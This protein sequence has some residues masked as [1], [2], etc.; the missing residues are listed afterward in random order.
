MANIT[1]Y[2]GP[3]KCG[4]SQKLFNEL[5][6]QLIAGKKLEIFKP[7]LDNR[8]GMEVISTRAGNSIKAH[9]IKNIKELK[10]YDADVYFID[11]FQFLDGDVSIIESIA[12]QE[13]KFYIAGLN[14][15]SENKPFGKMGDLLCIADK[16]EIMT[17]ICEIC[18]NDDAIFTY[19]KGKKDKDILIGDSD[20]IPVC[21][22]CY[23]NLQNKLV[24]INKKIINF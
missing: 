1:V 12:S 16:I 4:K 6:R 11:E 5:K 10:K 9:S 23:Y 7:D 19:Y 20:Y 14:L 8:N 17:S 15:T 2:T 18:K 24:K 13:K 21:R 3:M 22:N